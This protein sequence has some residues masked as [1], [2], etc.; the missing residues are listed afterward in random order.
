MIEARV[1]IDADGR[2]PQIEGHN[3]SVVLEMRESE[4]T[5]TKAAH[6]LLSLAKQRERERERGTK[7]A[8]FLDQM[9]PFPRLPLLLPLLFVINVAS[10]SPSLPS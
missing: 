4:S 5:P 8:W 2:R 7:D 3:H 6:P 1:L 10:F 9:E